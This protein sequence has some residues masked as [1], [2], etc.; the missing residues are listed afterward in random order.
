MKNNVFD[1][2]VCIKPGFSLSV[3]SENQV[4]MI[5]QATL[6]VMKRT[7]V[8]V[9]SKRA[10]DIFG[11]HGCTV[12]CTDRG[13]LVKFPA[14]VVEDSIRSA[15][16]QISLY[17][18]EPE[19]DFHLGP[20]ISTFA[21]GHCVVDVVDPFTREYRPALKKDC[22][23]IAKI[24]DYVSEFGVFS[25]PLYPND[26]PDVSIQLHNFEVIATNTSKH[27]FCDAGSGDKLDKMIEMGVAVSGGTN[28]FKERPFFSVICAPS[29]PL[30]IDSHCSDVIIR[31]ASEGICVNIITM[32]TAGGTS[33]TTPAGTIVV[34]NA[35]I[36]ASIVL[37]QLVRK[38]SPCIYGACSTMMDLR[39]G[40]PA[41]GA[42]EGGMI[43]AGAAVLSRFYELPSYL[44]PAFWTSSKIADLQSAYEGALLALTVLLAQGS[45]CWGAGIVN[46]LMA[47]DYAKL[48]MDSEAARNIRKILSGISV[49]DDSLATE[50]IH[51]VGPGNH[52][53][54][55]EHTVS[56]MRELS[57]KG[58]YDWSHRNEWLSNGS[59]SLTDRAYEKVEGI[60]ESHQPFPLPDDVQKTLRLIILEHERDNGLREF[61]LEV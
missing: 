10:A 13:H 44:G 40:V 43:Q 25:R 39:T 23:D 58:L 6:D 37:S 31:A 59:K 52:F 14:N 20:G 57:E 45:I 55:H 8:K 30:V 21:N 61:D 11:A 50:V 48:V 2:S 24:G 32:S 41:C 9:G 29:S 5:H 1:E 16:K 36:L 47:I 49:D 18:R 17:A 60:L 46:N 42:P 28:A 19:K 22:A 35:E 4:E 53:L 38:G 51:E 7:G 26:V 12:E 33:P 3:F 27:F 15:P 56:H 54:R 34:N